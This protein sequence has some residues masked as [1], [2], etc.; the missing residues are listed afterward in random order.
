MTTSYQ[1]YFC[2]PIASFAPGS[3]GK[4]THAIYGRSGTRAEK[5]GKDAFSLGARAYDVISAI[6]GEPLTVELLIELMRQVEPIFED[7][8]K[9]LEERVRVGA[10][11]LVDAETGKP[12]RRGRSLR[13]R[14]AS[15][16][17]KMRAF[18]VAMV[19]LAQGQPQPLSSFNIYLALATL[20]ELDDVVLCRLDNDAEGIAN[21]LLN[22]SWMMNQVDASDSAV[23]TAT[24]MLGK[25]DSE[26]ASSRAKARHAKDPKR[27]ARDFV[28]ECW[29]AW[30]NEPE[31]YPSTA[32]FARSMLDKFPDTLKSQAVIAGWVRSWKRQAD[33]G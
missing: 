28:Y 33:Q 26:R 27:A 3:I 4:R 30:N 20:V 13:W 32:A 31:H 11:T 5:I 1:F 16:S 22:A 24:L 9:T 6:N 23:Q 19:D 10:I 2:D 21:G 12:R 15:W 8:F 14:T 7:F 17:W 25:L 18:M 29:L